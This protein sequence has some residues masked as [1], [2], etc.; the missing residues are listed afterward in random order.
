MIAISILNIK[1]N[2]EKIKQMDNLNP[3]FIHLDI[4]DGYFVDNKVDLLNLPE[5]NSKKDIHLMVND[6]KKYIDIY[7][8]YYP[9]YIT[10]HLEAVENINEVIKEIKMLNIKVGISIKP[11]T[12]ID[13]LIPYLDEIDLV[14]VMSVEP[15]QGGQAF[16]DSSSDKIRQLCELRKVNNYN[17]VIEVDGGVNVYTKDKCEGADILVVGSYITMSDNYQ[18]AYYSML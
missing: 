3:D 5:L 4:M 2:K 18:E 16:I 1:D 17:Y 10:F 7:K 8:Q 11:N 12:P 6:V 13:M 14:L 9:E 15:G